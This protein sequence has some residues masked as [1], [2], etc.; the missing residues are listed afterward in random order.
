MSIKEKLLA[1]TFDD[2]PTDTS[3]VLLNGLKRRG[4]RATFFVIGNRIAGNEAVI[5]R[6]AEEGHTIG[7]HTF[8][9]IPL[10]HDGLVPL[11]EVNRCTDCIKCVAGYTPSLLRVPGLIYKTPSN[12]NYGDNG[13]YNPKK[14]SLDCNLAL[15]DCSFGTG[16]TTTDNEDVVYNTIKSKAK[17]GDIVLLHDRLSSINAAFRLIDSLQAEGYRFVTV[18]ELITA[19]DKQIKPGMVYKS[20]SKILE[21]F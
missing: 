6:M 7:N 20:A 12:T 13:L 2:A 5:R 8:N 19:M 10:Y 11:E 15:I 21:D 3:E 17:S 14:L 16:D 1:L 18:P 9:H 4:A